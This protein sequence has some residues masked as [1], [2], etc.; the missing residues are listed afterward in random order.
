MIATCTS[1]SIVSLIGLSYSDMG[2]VFRSSYIVQHNEPFS[3]RNP[4]QHGVSDSFI[5]VSVICKA[6]AVARQNFFMAQ[7]PPL[8][9]NLCIML[10]PYEFDS[11]AK[12][13]K[14][15]SAPVLQIGSCM[16]MLV[17]ACSE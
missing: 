14:I 7:A 4:V 1:W 6:A 3:G 11:F 16:P 8:P 17:Y 5:H 9:N 15:F 10:F 13:T 12:V 2:R